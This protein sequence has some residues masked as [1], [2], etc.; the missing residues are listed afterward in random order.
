M[1]PLLGH[2]TPAKKTNRGNQLGSP[3]TIDVFRYL[4]KCRFNLLQTLPLLHPPRCR[5]R[6]PQLPPFF[7]T[8]TPRNQLP[9]RPAHRL[10]GTSPIRTRLNLPP[11]FTDLYGPD[12]N[13]TL[14]IKV[15]TKRFFPLIG[16]SLANLIIILIGLIAL[17]LPGF[18]AMAGL[19]LTLPILL[20]E[21]RSVTDTLVRSFKL[22][23]GRL[24][25]LFFCLCIWIVIPVTLQMTMPL[26]LDET[27]PTFWI[28]KGFWTSISTILVISSSAYAFYILE[29]NEALEAETKKEDWL[30]VRNP[31]ILDQTE[32]PKDIA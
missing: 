22:A 11:L 2:T 10:L 15:V 5:N 29:R 19:F 27:S 21:Q 17:L 4:R 25:T 16:L 13:P 1:R 7:Q 28:L 12:N 14:A 9:I 18:I 6:N 23:Q 3:D 24:L 20:W 8:R 32:E 31:K 30:K 26:I